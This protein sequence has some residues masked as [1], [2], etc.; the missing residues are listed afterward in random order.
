MKRHI[1]TF[2]QFINE[3]DAN[4]YRPDAASTAD[5]VGKAIASIEE[6]TAGKEYV[7]T[8]DGENTKV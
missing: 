3:N 2:E 5:V 7:L 8:L 1:P 6:L 4:G